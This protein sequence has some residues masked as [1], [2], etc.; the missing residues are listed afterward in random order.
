ML[1]KILMLSLLLLSGCYHIKTEA[2][3][4][5]EREA[6]ARIEAQAQHVRILKEDADGCQYI[7][8]LNVAAGDDI[9]KEPYTYEAAVKKLQFRAAQAGANTAVIDSAIPP[10]GDH[11]GF[12][13]GARVFKCP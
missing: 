8:A 3:I 7:T 10:G 2:E 13:V 4:Q 11:W 5:S 1:K 9:M 12:R 6:R